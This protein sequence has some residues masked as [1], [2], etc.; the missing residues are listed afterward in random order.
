M[1]APVLRAWIYLLLSFLTLHTFSLSVSSCDVGWFGERCQY[2]C[3][4]TNS[5]CDLQGECT[6][7]SKCERGWFGPECQYQDL[8]VNGRI[9]TL[10]LQE[11]DKVLDGDEDTCHDN[12]QQMIL[13][14]SINYPLTW[15]RIKVLESDPDQL[16]N[17]TVLLKPHKTHDTTVINHPYINCSRKRTSFVNN[18]TVDV[19]CDV[20]E[21]VQEIL[22]YGAGI[23]TLCAV[24]VSGGRNVALKQTAWQSSTSASENAVASR[25]VD[26]KWLGQFQDNSCTHTDINDKTPVL[27]LTLSQ[28]ANINRFEILNRNDC[29]QRRLMYFS[30]ETRSA[31]NDSVHVYRDAADAPQNSYTIVSIDPKEP[32]T[33][34][35]VAAHNEWQGY[36]VLTLCEVELYGDS[37]CPPG[38][39]GLECNETCN[40]AIKDDECF[41]S[42]GTCALGCA[43]GYYGDGCKQA[44]PPHFWGVNCLSRCSERCSGS[45]CDSVTGR[46]VSGCQ[47]GYKAPDCTEVCN[48]GNYG[49]NCTL[50]CPA[51]CANGT[52]DHVTG[53]CVCKAGFHGASCSQAYSECCCNGT[54]NHVTGQCPLCVK[55]HEESQI[56]TCIRCEQTTQDT[57]IRDLFIALFIIS[58]AVIVILVMILWRRFKQNWNVKRANQKVDAKQLK[59]YLTVRHQSGFPQKPSQSANNGVNQPTTESISQQRSQS[60]NNG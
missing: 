50:A 12:L 59:V 47:L 25:A 43:A 15:F 21:G 13:T 44:C 49:A 3:H 36:V 14:W 46:C 28:P 26:G 54:C 6:N 42:T 19:Y 34:F 24:Y 27:K 29:C 20:R 23:K 16:L 38:K 32:V 18:R 31:K 8:A 33:T 45:T 30:F 41:V 5:S 35:T 9:L 4:C 58:L 52:C 53:S 56:P 60:A 51:N 55:G 22:V 37:A 2:K 11:R 17:L 39:Y 40:C 57:V 7:G 10:P 1:M 48:P